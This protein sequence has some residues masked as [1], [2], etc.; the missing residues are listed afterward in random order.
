[1]K[2]FTK[3]IFIYCLLALLALQ[4]KAQYGNALSYDPLNS[5]FTTMPTG[6]VS[7]IPAGTNFT[8]EAWV[9]WRGGGAYQRIFD[10]GTG[11]GA[12][13][14]LT[15]SNGG[16][17]AFGFKIPGHPERQIAAG[18]TPMPVNT[19]SHVAIVVD[20]S[21]NDGFGTPGGFLY[22]N[23]NRVVF[24]GLYDYNGVTATP[25][26]ASDLAGT[27]QNW[28]GRSQSAFDPYFDGIIDEVR[29]SN[30]IRYSGATYT[31]PT[32]PFTIDASTLALYHFN[33]GTGQTSVDATSNNAAAILGTTGAVEAADPS[34]SL[35][36]LPV[37]ISRFSVQKNSNSV[38]LKWT[39]ST[40][41]EQGQFVVE[42]SSDGSH[43]SAIG[44]VEISKKPGTVDYTFTDHSFNSNKNYYR[45]KIQENNS[46]AKY[47]SI[48]FVNMLV[49]YAVYPTFVKDHIYIT[50]PRQT[51]IAIYNSS[52]ALMQK[53]N[54]VSS[55]D[56][57]VTTLPGGIYYVMFEDSKQII[58]FSKLR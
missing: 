6:I 4:T 8:I 15:P 26:N 29:I 9:Y 20:Y 37:K 55:Q 30:T 12:Y 14:Y 42:R 34:W 39:A 45:L 31:K 13:M 11:T 46:E 24:G 19:W 47:S 56:V 21:Y 51:N 5:Q 35:S 38:D 41:D 7:S 44:S 25:Y 52:G 18:A 33:E 40:T 23:G 36:I 3:S 2:N 10:F 27:E 50:I 43:F 28:L 17:V 57:D 54:L 16:G 49:D 53:A 32:A 1:M 22:L 48:V 58:R